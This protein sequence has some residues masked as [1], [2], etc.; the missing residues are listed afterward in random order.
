MKELLIG[1]TGQIS[2]AVTR[3]LLKDGWEVW[4]LN[5]GNRPAEFDGNIHYIQADINNEE[6]V[7]EAIRDLHFDCVCEWIGYTPDQMERDY[8]LF[9]DHTNQN[10]FTSSATVYQRPPVISSSL[11]RTDASCVS[12]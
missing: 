1:G 3:K 2:S 10:L 7:K 9:K 5:R 11:F 4:L 8:R 12:D 6:T